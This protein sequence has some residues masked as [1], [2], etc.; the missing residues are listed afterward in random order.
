MRLGRHE[1]AR[2]STQ[3]AKAGSHPTVTAGDIHQQHEAGQKHKKKKFDG[4][5]DALS[6]SLSAVILLIAMTG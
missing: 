3:P 6:V 1:N 4:I 5:A 2:A